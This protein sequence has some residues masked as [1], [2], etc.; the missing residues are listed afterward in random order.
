VA[1]GPA[2]T[3]SAG[4][5]AGI[6]VAAGGSAKPGTL[7]ALHVATSSGWKG[8]GSRRLNGNRGAS[9]YVRPG[10]TTTYRVAVVAPNGTAD[11]I[12]KPVRITVQAKGMAVVAEASK[13]KGKPYRYGAAGPNSFDCSGYTQFVYRKF[14]KVLPHSATQQG[15]LG[16]YV[17]K[18]AARPGDLIV[19]GSPGRYHHAGI[20][21]GN[22][23]MWDSSTSG[24]P[25]A[26]RKIWSQNYQIR[27]LV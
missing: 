2:R 20:V 9:F 19:F 3:I 25:V 17:A 23:Y 6:Y 13:H 14:G 22:G 8:G 18:N 12:S 26:L 5:T 16:T 27:R 1:A 7:V 21:A 15:R 24:Q 11:S 10:V 4:Q